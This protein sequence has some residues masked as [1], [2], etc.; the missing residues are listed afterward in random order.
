MASFDV[1]P[2][3]LLLLIFS[4]LDGPGLAAASAACKTWEAF[5]ESTTG[6]VTSLSPTGSLDYLF[7][8]ECATVRLVSLVARAAQLLYI[9]RASLWPPGN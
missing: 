2:P 1:L 8:C 5:L 4:E 9:N 6:E 7:V 3:E